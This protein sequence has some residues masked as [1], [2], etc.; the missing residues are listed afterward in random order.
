MDDAVESYRD[1]LSRTELN[2][3]REIFIGRVIRELSGALEN[4][5]GQEETQSFAA[6]VGAMIGEDWNHEYRRLFGESALSLEQVAAALI[7]LKTRIG[8]AHY[9]ESID[10]NQIVLNSRRCPFDAVAEGRPTLCQMTSSMFGR[11][12]ADNLG[13]ARVAV[14]ESLSQGRRECR[15]V[16]DLCD[17]GATPEN[18]NEYFGR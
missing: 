1:A 17:T 11:I 6:M 5:V 4:V 7:D 10:E 18:C 3:S 14:R 8:G 16:I 13:Y 9:I 12:V 2:H 15:I